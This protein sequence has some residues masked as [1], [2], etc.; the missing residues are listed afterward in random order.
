LNRGWG[1]SYCTGFSILTS[2]SSESSRL[3][4]SSPSSNEP[5]PSISAR[6]RNSSSSSAFPLPRLP[7]RSLAP[8]CFFAG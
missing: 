7:P 3:I 5:L 1:I 6:L 4:G 2:S 8:P